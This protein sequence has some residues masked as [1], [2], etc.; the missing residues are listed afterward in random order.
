MEKIR[1]I[2]RITSSMN[3]SNYWKQHSIDKV[4]LFIYHTKIKEARSNLLNHQILE[5]DAELS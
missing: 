3:A 1:N 2:G 4:I 5:I